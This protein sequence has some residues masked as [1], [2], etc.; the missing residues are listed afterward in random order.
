MAQRGRST[1][2][3]GS[4]YGQA[5]QSVSAIFRRGDGASKS[6]STVNF[7]AEVV[8]HTA[9][10]LDALL[11]HNGSCPLCSCARP[12]C[13]ITVL[14]SALDFRASRSG[15]GIIPLEVLPCGG[16]QFAAPSP[17]DLPDARSLASSR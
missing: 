17:L 3:N 14:L 6:V 8:G 11:Q 4:V 5:T 13:D 10:G 9:R 7:A 15:I 16:A 1:S 2:N 12:A